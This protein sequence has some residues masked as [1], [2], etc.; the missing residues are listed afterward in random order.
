MTALEK[1][2]LRQSKFTFSEEDQKTSSDES[3]SPKKSSK[4]D[5]LPVFSSAVTKASHP[6][7]LPS[8]SNN[9]IV[10]LQQRVMFCQNGEA[11]SLSSTMPTVHLTNFK[12]KGVV[13]FI[14]PN[15]SQCGG[16]I[17]MCTKS[18]IGK[19][20][21]TEKYATI[22]ILPDPPESRSSVNETVFVLPGSP[23][24]AESS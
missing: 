19:R 20:E 4:K 10:D 16:N 13:R 17:L 8:C 2:T 6:Y 7:A 9:I 1:T 22:T 3:M 23:V 18:R 24:A 14:T 11:L 5:L 21:E 15:G 12:V